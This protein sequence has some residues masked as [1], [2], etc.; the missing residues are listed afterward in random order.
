[1]LISLAWKNIWRNKRRSLIIITAIG[2]GLWGGLLAD[3]LMM[4]W[5]ESMVNTAIDRDLAHIQLHRPGFA[6]DRDPAQFIPEGMKVMQQIRQTPGVLAVSGRTL[7]DGMAASPIA[8]FGVRIT[9]IDPSRAEKVTAI[10]DLIIEGRYFGGKG[11]NPIVIGNKLAERLSLKCHSKVV[12]SFQGMDGTLV[13]AA[14]R[15]EGIFKSDSSLFDESHVF[16]RRSDLLRL[17]GTAPVI[18]EIAVRVVSSSRVAGVFAALKA[19][20]PGLSIETWK[21][22]SP[23]IAAT[24]AAM[25]SWSYIFV[26]IILMALVF[27]ITNTMLMAVMER[28]QE[29]GILIAVGMKRGKVFLMILLETLML[30]LTGGVLGMLLGGASIGVLSWTG[31]DFSAF[32]SSL[33][34]FGASTTLYPYLPDEAYPA[35]VAMIVVAASIAA[36]LPAWKAIHLRPAAAIRTQ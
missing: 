3:A 21:T 7:V 13:Y 22:L 32:A 15:V 27:G 5:G 10:H 1:L 19:A 12:L 20:Y 31:I 4:G 24:A 23:E 18:Q 30:S 17:L 26:G 11:R 33:G 28:V 14:F 35:L 2:F 29:L 9:G 8:T 34:T 36:A 6:R 16:V 25:E